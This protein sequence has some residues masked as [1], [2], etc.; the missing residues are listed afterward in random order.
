MLVDE[1]KNE[2]LILWLNRKF[3]ARL[4]IVQKRERSMV[5]EEQRNETRFQTATYCHKPAFR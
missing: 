4:P 5:K 2:M 1:P 3:S